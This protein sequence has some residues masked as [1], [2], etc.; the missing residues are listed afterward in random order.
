MRLTLYRTRLEHVPAC[1]H[2]HDYTVRD[3]AEPVGRLY[4][5]RASARPELAWFWLITVYLD[6]RAEIKTT[7]TAA[8]LAEAKA[9]FRTSWRKWLKWKGRKASRGMSRLCAD[10]SGRSIT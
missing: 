3:R 4:Q 7:G 10:C 1:A 6:P 8:D 2:V 9:A 5:V